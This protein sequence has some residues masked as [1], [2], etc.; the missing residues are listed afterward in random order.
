MSAHLK[1]KAM[2]TTNNLYWELQSDA[3]IYYF[4]NICYLTVLVA[5]QE[6]KY[7]T[8]TYWV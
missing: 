1:Q 2:V 8:A 4:Q 7:D 5:M 6:N 3:S